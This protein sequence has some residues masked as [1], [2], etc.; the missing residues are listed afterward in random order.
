MTNLN[1]VVSYE[2]FYG[3]L[4]EWFVLAVKLAKKKKQY[5]WQQGDKVPTLCQ[6]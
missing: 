1:I 6:Q 5:L 4:G 3:L 2:E